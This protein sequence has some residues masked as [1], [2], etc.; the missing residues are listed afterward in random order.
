MTENIIAFLSRAHGLEVLKSILASSNYNIIQLYTHKLN[1]K[2]QDS[3]RNQ[4]QD[5]YL[6]EEICLQ[7]KIPLFT[8]DDKND[9]IK[10]C[11]TCDF[12]IEVS[13]RYIIPS[14]VTKKAKI[15]AF[16]I[17]RGK[18][19]DYAGAEP[20]K[21]ALQNNE[22]IIIISAHYLDDIIDDGD[23]IFSL[24][25]PVN[26]NVNYNIEYNVQKLRDETTPLFS[27]IAMKTF[28]I[29]KKSS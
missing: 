19:P 20:I 3:S 4:R 17:H 25:H 13:W 8:I 26:Y 1:P 15:G 23:T 28:E 12:I 9:E 24:S 5:Y 22:K 2:S 21:Q 10:D 6:Y 27:K 14:Y 18:L 11:P 16:G 29:L 7:N